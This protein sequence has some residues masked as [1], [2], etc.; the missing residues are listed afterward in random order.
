MME[1]SVD[2]SFTSQFNGS[3]TA[4]MM[5]KKEQRSRMLSQ[6]IAHSSY[7]SVVTYHF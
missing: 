6:T 2:L 3:N 1:Q 4:S 7:H 5:T